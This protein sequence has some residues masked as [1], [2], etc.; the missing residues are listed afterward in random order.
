MMVW[1]E[2]LKMIYYVCLILS[3]VIEE[4]ESCYS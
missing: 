2:K 4:C 1:K 3:E